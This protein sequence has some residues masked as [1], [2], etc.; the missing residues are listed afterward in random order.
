VNSF[1]TAFLQFPIYDSSLE[2]RN[3]ARFRREA[4]PL[5]E[6]AN[7]FYIPTGRW[8]SRGWILMR[9]TD[10]NLINTYSTSLQLQIG[11]PRS[12]DNVG[13]LQNLSIVQA[14]CVTRGVAADPDAI[15][16]VE[17][18][19]D[20]SI[21]DNKWFQCPITSAYNVRVPAY[22][23][24]FYPWSL[25]AGSPWTWSTM[26]QD[27]WT[28]MSAIGGGG[29]I[30]GAW[31]G[32]PSAPTG[33]PEGFWF[34]GVPIWVAFND[35]IE[36]LGM[37]VAP[38]LTKANPYTIVSAGAADAAFAA[39]QAKY[40][41]VG[42]PTYFLEDDLEWI[43]TGAGRVPATV[44][45]LFRRRN[46]VYGTEETVRVDSPYQWESAAYYTVSINAPAQFASAVGVH[47]LWSDF[48]VEYDMDGNPLAADVATASAIAA[49]RVT[50]Y[51]ARIYR[52]TAGF[53][54]QTYAGALPFVCGSQVD[55]VCYYQDY[56]QGD[57]GW[58]TKI[59]R[60]AYP[61]FPEVYDGD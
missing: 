56:R 7:S 11:D 55:G 19:D 43:D 51:F 18:C 8:P 1:G 31:P 42:S 9:R 14:Q 39:L 41:G 33:T 49:E 24:T 59:V 45:V 29:Q 21:L 61:P 48:T 17:L 60:G 58:R 2:R 20:Q 40:G 22:P 38:D 26:L 16:L 35:V 15:Y 54:T 57:G 50:Q 52:Q 32:L 34:P 53:M 6:R 5:L 10:Y 36:Y 12:R 25:N 13:V 37:T 23:Q 28:Q 46:Q 27:M 4:L 3:R 30:L 44:K 47:F